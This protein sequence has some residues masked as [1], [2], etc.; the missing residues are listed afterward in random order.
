[1]KS[2]IIKLLH[3]AMMLLCNKGDYGKAIITTYEGI[4]FDLLNPSFECIKA[5][6]IA[7][8]LAYKPHFLGFS[9]RFFSIA[10]HSIIVYNLYKQEYPYDFKGQLC[11]LLHDASEA[12]TNDIV[13]PLKN[14]LPYFEVIEHSIQT[15]IWEQYNLLDTISQS[16][17]KTY[18]K[19]CDIR[20]QSIEYME[21]Y[22]NI[23]CIQ[24][25]VNIINYY[26]PNES[27][28]KFMDI[29]TSLIS[30]IQNNKTNDITRN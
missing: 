3:K 26:T 7:R 19:A 5:E 14:K 4:R 23:V 6:D 28:N 10:E 2:F 12:Y 21:F 1:M 8:G 17:V 18:I 22:N 15:V 25:G 24:D 20:S 16:N 27:Y 30:N 11:A 9:P 29:F 13:K